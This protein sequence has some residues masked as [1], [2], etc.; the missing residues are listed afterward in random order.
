[1]A[2]LFEQQ[3]Q[4]QQQQAE[5]NLEL[6]VRD[7]L[8]SAEQR[9][10]AVKAASNLDFH[11]AAVRDLEMA[12]AQSNFWDDQN[13]A[14]RQMAELAGHQRILAQVSEW[15]DSLQNVQATLELVEELEQSKDAPEAAELLREARA[16]LASLVR[17]LD[18]DELERMLSGPYD[19][20]GCTLLITAGAGGTD[21][22][23]WAEML[24][25][26]YLRWAERRG[27]KTDL[28]EVSSGDVAG[29]KSATV[30]IV[31]D[32]AYGWCRTET[33]VHRLVRKS[34]F[35][36]GNRRHTSFAAVFVSPEVD[37]IMKEQARAWRGDWSYQDMAEFL[38][39]NGL[40]IGAY[41]LMGRNVRGVTKRVKRRE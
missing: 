32:Y 17:T 19:A 12:S 10:Q 4:Q 36:S 6:Y 38:K 8:R 16:E 2:P 37:D 29:I 41:C 23:D 35:D 3:Q 33:G 30:H 24:L 31:G 13:Q 18:Q 7:A 1:M 40:S 15:Q 9:V 39:R 14:Q 27:W 28:V 5:V 25:R 11:R 21:A 20:C 22:Q 26:M 34:P